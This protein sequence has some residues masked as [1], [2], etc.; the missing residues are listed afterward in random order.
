[1]IAMKVNI[2]GE[3]E[4]LHPAILIYNENTG[5]SIFI[6]KNMNFRTNITSYIIESETLKIKI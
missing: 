2:A 5:E 6:D 1:M 4:N 3:D